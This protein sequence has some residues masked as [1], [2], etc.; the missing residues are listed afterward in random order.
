M[1]DATEKTVR[2][3]STGGQKYVRTE[4]E[5]RAL[6]DMG[7]APLGALDLAA[8]AAEAGA[9][10][11]RDA[12]DTA[13]D[14][15]LTFAE[16][17]VDAL[18]LGLIHDPSP[19]ADVRRDVNDG[20][21]LM[22]QLTGTAVGIFGGG[23]LKYLPENIV[24]RG[25]SKAGKA[26]AKTFLGDVKA[27]SRAAMVDRGIEGA[28]E[29]AALMG[30]ASVGRQF[31][32]S[33]IGDKEFAASAVIADAGLGAIM[34]GGISLL[35]GMFTRAASRYDVKGQGDLIDPSSA[36]AAGLVDHVHT[37]KG[38]WDNALDQHAQR[39][40]V[41]KQLEAEGLLDNVVPEFM[42]NR[43]LAL[44]SAQGARKELEAIDFGAALGGNEK[45]FAR[46]QHHLTRYE[47][48]LGDLDDLMAPRML[49]RMRPHPPATPLADPGRPVTE[50]MGIPREAVEEMDGLMRD[51]ARAA[52]YEVIHGRPYRPQTEV[53]RAAGEASP[54]S[55][56]GTPFA[57]GTPR[58][59]QATPDAVQIPAPAPGTPYVPPPLPGPGS[60]FNP[61]EWTPAR[62]QGEMGAGRVISPTVK[63]E[64]LDNVL[65]QAHADLAKSQLLLPD[66]YYGSVA[67]RDQNAA[68][69]S[70]FRQRMAV[71]T[72]VPGAA[73]PV[74]AAPTPVL[75]QRDSR[76]PVRPRAA[77]P[78][79]GQ[80]AVRRYVDEWYATADQVGPRFSPGDHAAQEIRS[81]AQKLQGTALG[82]EVAASSTDLAKALKLPEPTTSLAA[83]LQS[84]YVMRRV[85]DLAATASK[86]T[87]MRGIAKG[88]DA[89]LLDWIVKR[90]V[91]RTAGQ[92]GARAALGMGGKLAG[93]LGYFAAQGVAYQLMGFAG[94]A[95]GAAGR[96]YQ[97]SLKAAESLLRGKRATFWASAATKSLAPNK[98][99]AYSD[100]GPIKDPIKR[101]EELHRVASSPATIADFIARA[102]GDLNL[103]SPE[104][105]QAAVTVATQQLAFLQ[106]MAPPLR[107]DRLGRII[108]PSTGAV[109]RFLEAE[110]AIFDLEG[111]LDAVAKGHVTKVQV[112][113]LRQGHTQVYG[114][115]AA[116]LLND[117]EKLQKLERAKLAT[118][119]M[120]TG[121][122]LTMA[123]DPEYVMRQQM[124]WA[125]EQMPGQTVAGPTQALNIPGAPKGGGYNP[126]G[127]AEANTTPAQSYGTSGRAPGN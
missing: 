121:V 10:R 3:G 38:A 127:P 61:A 93:P 125:P 52:E 117:P 89:A 91:L 66:G 41:L 11:R 96:L 60:R 40:G 87:A 34:G 90:S 76:S 31:T 33:V 32:D 12:F 95:A 2:T 9:Q 124:A 53:P 86:G 56:L 35:S 42:A 26:V 82:R 58:D 29:M 15:A 59:V 118:I 51:P 17:M 74:A 18:T 100:A 106:S 78:T 80:A 5:A 85:S 14:A 24:M 94:R 69:F 99:V 4:E 110:N 108:Q 25:G 116:F 8:E 64:Q 54:T 120:V 27:G 98:P 75:R 1:G 13:G 30:A 37:A 28:G 111:V 39:L 36:Q 103:V 114:K 23:P 43:E 50:Q 83:E 84:L 102:A 119:Q 47:Q 48:A 79:A 104:F 97:K 92:I 101:I 107:Y 88:R 122:P 21:A 123:A 44:A 113:A 19:A 115:I 70:E 62:V 49:E 73:R 65:S 55:E 112:D 22:G 46:F 105:V 7:E 63:A 67:N 45:S 77:E 71:D 68:A 72:P 109:R 6:A 16:G 57:K 20:M 126:R 81:I